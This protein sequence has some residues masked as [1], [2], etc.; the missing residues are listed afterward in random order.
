MAHPT[1]SVV[2]RSLAAEAGISA[3]QIG[4]GVSLLGRVA[5][6]YHWTFARAF[7]PLSTGIERACK[8]ALQVDARLNSQS[9]LTR[10][11]L[12]DKG[13]RLDRLIAAVD[14]IQRQRDAT[15][16]LPSNPVHHAVIRTLTEFAVGG[17]YHHLDHL[18]G[19]GGTDPIASWW[20][21]VVEPI[22]DEHYPESRK[23]RDQHEAA[24][25]G[26][27]FG[28]AALVLHTHVGGGTMGS[29][30]RAVHE[31][32]RNQFAI[33]WVRMHVLQIARWITAVMR[34]LSDASYIARDE[35]IPA[36]HEFFYHFDVSD[37]EM[38]RRKTWRS[39]I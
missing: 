24:A 30:A 2:W 16:V 27:A 26:A 34:I 15:V 11:E 25:M 19:N 31:S 17:R 5:P 6:E 3:D 7:F 8:L 4:E 12:Q 10:A 13:H 33:P 1:E 28:D 21:S 18:A 22:L 29:L 32:Q 14:S 20:S 36:L 9:F 39:P 37:S 23:Q 35:D 38:R